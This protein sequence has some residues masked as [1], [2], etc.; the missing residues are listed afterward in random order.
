MLFGKQAL[1]KRAMK[2]ALLFLLAPVILFAQRED[3]WC[4]GESAQIKF[5]GGTVQPNGSS[6]L[7]SAEECASISD[8]TGNLLF[9]A[10]PNYFHSNGWSPH[11]LTIWD[12]NNQVM[13]NGDSLFGNISA[14][15]GTMILPMVNDTSSYYVLSVNPYLFFQG[16]YCSL[17]DMT[18]NSGLGAVVLRDSLLINGR[19]AEKLIAVKHSNGKDWWILVHQ[20]VLNDSSNVFYKLL[21]DSSGINYPDSQSI[22]TYYG[23]PANYYR[24]IAGEMVFSEDGSKLVST[25]YGLI[26]LFDF[27]RCT[28]EL[29]N[30]QSLAPPNPSYPSDNFYGASFSPNGSRLYISSIANSLSLTSQ[31]LYQFDLTAANIIGSRTLIHQLNIDLLNLGQHQIGP[32][33]KIYIATSYD[34]FPLQHDTICNLNLSVINSPDSL[35]VGCDFQLFCIP[36][37]NGR[38]YVGLPNMPNYNLGPLEVN[39]DSI[40]RVGDLKNIFETFAIIPN[41]NRG[42]FKVKYSSAISGPT[43]I[44]IN[45]FTGKQLI[46][47]EFISKAGPN[48]KSIDASTF[49]KGFYFISICTSSSTIV[50]KIIIE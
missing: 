49:D 41:P 31:Y 27:N 12:R 18:Q 14:T 25:G 22:G 45:D 21:V 24:G 20:I 10:G 19:L 38:S 33:G 43:Q 48:E 34:A 3:T 16:L 42:E 40:N 13:Q 46:S 26:D 6:S 28:G 32:N 37:G 11:D 15:N 9:Y 36:I 44:Y 29:S 7:F 23:N 39:C 2:L 1:N 17:V 35:G 47:F 5:I 4:F 8:Q 50:S 30:W